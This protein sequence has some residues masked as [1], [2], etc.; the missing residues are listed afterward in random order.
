[1]LHSVYPFTVPEQDNKQQNVALSP[2]FGSKVQLDRTQMDMTALYLRKTRQMLTYTFTL[3]P[4]KSTFDV[5][6]WR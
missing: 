4:V 2:P 3:T 5:P 6:L 1:M